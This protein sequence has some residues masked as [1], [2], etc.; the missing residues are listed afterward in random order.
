MYAAAPARR[1]RKISQL[2]TCAGCAPFREFEPAG[3]AVLSRREKSPFKSLCIFVASNLKNDGHDTEKIVFNRFAD[4]R[5]L[6]IRQHE[7]AGLASIPRSRPE[8]YFPAKGLAARM[9]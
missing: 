5:R 9:V 8:Q 1:E 7:R 6:H 4:R 3:K 2:M